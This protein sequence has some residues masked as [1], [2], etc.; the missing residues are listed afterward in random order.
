MQDPITVGG[1]EKSGIHEE[2]K[3]RKTFSSNV[4]IMTR[5]YRPLEYKEGRK[6][7]NMQ[8]LS[9]NRNAVS[10]GR[11]RTLRLGALKSL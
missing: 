7:G 6:R 11:H 9:G 5:Q 10:Q 2:T 4:T 8:F 1:R 3:E